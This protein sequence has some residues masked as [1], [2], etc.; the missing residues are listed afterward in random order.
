MTRTIQGASV[1]DTS[2]LESGED[3]KKLQG[4]DEKT[5]E[6]SF[7]LNQETSSDENTG[8]DESIQIGNDIHEDNNQNE[9]TFEEDDEETD[10][11]IETKSQL[12]EGTNQEQPEAEG[13]SQGGRRGFEF[14]ISEPVTEVSQERLE[15]IYEGHLKWVEALLN[16][17][18][19]VFEGRANLSGADLS[20]FNLDG[21]NFSG[22]SFKETNLRGASL[23]GTNFTGADLTGADLTGAVCSK[24]KFR[25]TILNRACFIGVDLESSDL[26]G[27]VQLGTVF[28]E[29][30][31]EEKEVKT[32]ETSIDNPQED[33]DKLSKE[34]TTL[35]L[36]K[37]ELTGSGKVESIQ[38]ELT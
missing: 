3:Q 27:A 25:R 5:K 10:Q 14:K 9:T 1:V 32:A 4:L 36:S 31:K 24:T 28:K 16:P 8:L 37:D 2:E 13:E 33:K 20:G 15:V 17:N 35:E 7:G 18:R 6:E 12:D 26:T 30:E 38:E 22:A 29:K 11:N 21:M 34:D 23:I 19:K